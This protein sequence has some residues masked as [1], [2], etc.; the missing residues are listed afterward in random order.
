MN[1]VNLF[2]CDRLVIPECN[3]NMSSLRG[4]ASWA[5]MTSL[6]GKLTAPACHLT[7]F[8]NKDE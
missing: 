1:G 4:K 8:V 5:K 2:V 3:Q 6:M 7:K